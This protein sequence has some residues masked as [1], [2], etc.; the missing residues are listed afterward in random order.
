M[1]V[2]TVDHVASDAFVDNSV[3]PAKRG[4]AKSSGIIC[5]A[6][7]NASI[8]EAMR[9]GGI[10]KVHHVDYD[11]KNILFIYSEVNTIVYGE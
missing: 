11:V 8:G 3:R 10:T 6:T 9:N 5:F 7:G 2:I 4:E 1:A